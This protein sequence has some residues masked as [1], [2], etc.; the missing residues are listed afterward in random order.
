LTPAVSIG[1]E[2][3]RAARDVGVHVIAE[4]MPHDVDGL[5]A[6]VVSAVVAR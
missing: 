5:V 1:P 4:A 2:T 6:A 3:T